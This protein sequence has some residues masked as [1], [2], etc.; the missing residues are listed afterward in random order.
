MDFSPPNNQLRSLIVSSGLTD[1]MIVDSSRAIIYL[2]ASRQ[3]QLM[4]HFRKRESTNQN[5]K[6][7][8]Q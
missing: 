7:M 2:L 6:E 3:T 4:Y 5:K 1:K 8:E